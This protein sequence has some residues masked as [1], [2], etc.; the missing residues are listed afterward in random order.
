MLSRFMSFFINANEA[1][2]GGFR[3]LLDAKNYPKSCL[4]KKSGK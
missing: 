4:R 2:N 3:G 1:K